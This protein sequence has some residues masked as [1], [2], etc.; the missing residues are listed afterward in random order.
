MCIKVCSYVF[1]IDSPILKL[2]NVS[3][4]STDSPLALES[5]SP[6]LPKVPHN[7]STT[8]PLQLEAW[9]RA[10]QSIPDK[11]FV[12]YVLRGIR[13]GFCTVAK[14]G[15]QYKPSKRNLKSAYEHTNVIITKRGWAYD[16]NGR[17]PH[18][19]HISESVWGNS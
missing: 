19:S 13:S 10:F 12:N 18:S 1:S 3:K 11:P 5:A 2:S 14:E 17:P 7:D 9:D 16:A 4:G 6:A 8:S 15:A